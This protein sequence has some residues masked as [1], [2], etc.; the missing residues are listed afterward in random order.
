[1]FQSFI[2]YPQKAAKI[3]DGIS[4]VSLGANH[5]VSDLSQFLPIRSLHFHPNQ[6]ACFEHAALIVGTRD[7]HG[8]THSS[9][10]AYPN[11]DAEKPVPVHDA[12]SC[13]SAKPTQSFSCG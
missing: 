4:H 1:V 12:T 9:G 6:F 10:Q 7:D 2:A 5:K 3:E 13:I 11:D 8:A